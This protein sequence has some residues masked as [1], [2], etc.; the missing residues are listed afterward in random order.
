M[1]TVQ[2]VL[3]EIKTEELGSVLMHEHVCTSS[4]GVALSYPD[5]YKRQDTFFLVIGLWKGNLL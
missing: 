1:K 2:T 4:M 5:V 3:G